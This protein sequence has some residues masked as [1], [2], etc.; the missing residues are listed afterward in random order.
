MQSLLPPRML[1]R[2]DTLATSPS[3]EVI[4][5]NRI[6]SKCHRPNLTHYTYCETCDLTPSEPS[7]PPAEPPIPLGFMD[8]PI[9]KPRR[10]RRRTRP[11]VPYNPPSGMEWSW[12][13]N[14]TR[15]TE[16]WALVPIVRYDDS[17]S[18]ARARIE[19]DAAAGRPLTA[20]QLAF[21]FLRK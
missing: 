17:S 2:C 7:R 20:E 5:K 6:C 11:E 15:S 1:R 13:T 3:G 19:A 14:L 9:R 21:A 16:G 4:Y 12:V 10:K 18:S 8:T